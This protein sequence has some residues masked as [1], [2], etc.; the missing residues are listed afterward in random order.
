MTGG[1]PYGVQKNREKLKAKKDEK[2]K[3]EK[4][5]SY[6]ISSGTATEEDLI[7]LKKVK[8]RKEIHK[9]RL[10]GLSQDDHIPDGL[11]DS[12]PMCTCNKNFCSINYI[13][14]NKTYYRSKCQECQDC[15]KTTPD[16]KPKVS[17][18]Q[19]SGYKKKTNCDLCGFRSVY[20]SQITV[21]H[22]DGNLTNVDFTNLRSICLNC[23]EVVKRKEINW[24]RGDLIPD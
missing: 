1:A 11:I 20:A 6:R 3:L 15:R 22:I 23:I 4:E 21:Y 8:D 17:N 9:K 13:R 5:R 2:E 16:K 10:L 14:N 12:R 24:K 19:K 18:W 7:Y